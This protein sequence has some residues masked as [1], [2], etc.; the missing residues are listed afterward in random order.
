MGELIRFPTS[1]RSAG[2]VPLWREAVGEQLRLERRRQGRLL[3]ELAEASGISQQYLSEIE[4]GLKDP[5]SEML[6]AH[7]EV[8]DLT[9]GQLTSRAS[10]SVQRAESA[11]GPQLRVA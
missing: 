11:S 3:R 7:A 4:R 2:H 8:L 10:R 1:K 6:Q 5:S 9:L